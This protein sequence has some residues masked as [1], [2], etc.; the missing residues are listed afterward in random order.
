MGIIN[1]IKMDLKLVAQREKTDLSLIFCLR[2]FLITGGFQYVLC[3]RIQEGLILIPIIGRPARRIFW[4]MTNMIFGSEI[5]IGAK[6]G[7]GLYIPHPYGIVAGVC[8]IGENVTLLQN[9]T[10]GV[11]NGSDAGIA[12]IGDNAFLSAGCVIL[13]DVKIGKGATIGANSVVL[14]DVPDDAIAIGVPA[15]IKIKTP[16]LSAL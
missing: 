10:I 13:G 8:E 12:V 4:W 7:G 15:K 11:K 3:R 1:K 6:V 2:M 9:V 16:N 5:A 14:S